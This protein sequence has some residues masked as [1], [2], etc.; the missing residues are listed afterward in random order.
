M[1][2]KGLGMKNN[3]YNA[4]LFASTLFLG[5]TCNAF[6]W[7][8]YFYAGAG[9]GQ[10]R[11]KD[12][13]TNL[14]G[15]DFDGS[16][17]DKVVGYR[18]VGGYKFAEFLGVELSYVDLGEF[19]ISGT[20][21]GAAV[22]AKTKAKGWQLLAV[23]TLAIDEEFDLFG[24]I[25]VF[26]WNEDAS[27][28][29]DSTAFSKSESGNSLTFGLGMKWDITQHFSLRGE[30]ERFQSIGKDNTTGKAD[31]NLLSVTGLWRF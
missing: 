7:D 1:L 26:R 10:S 19:K 20:A 4:F 27:G 11:S 21:A 25:G 23:G 17:K 6:A 16:C 9:I 13:C 28:T 12:A 29:I 22:D 3:S 15:S 14:G 24:K 5:V 8:S 2:I 30:W 31:V 18:L